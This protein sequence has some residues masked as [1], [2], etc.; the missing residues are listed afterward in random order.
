MNTLMQKNII[1][2]NACGS[3]FSY[4]L[5]DNNDFLITEYKV[6]QSRT[7]NGFVKC[8]KMMNNGQVELYYLTS[9]FRS[10]ADVKKNLTSEIFLTIVLNIFTSI[11]NAKN[12]GFL[13]CQNID[14]SF[15]K[16][17]IDANT[18]KVSLI[19]LPLSKNLFQDYSI[20]EN[21]LRTSLIKFISKSPKLI[22]PKVMQLFEELSNGQI[23]LTELCEHINGGVKMNKGDGDT[24]NFDKKVNSK[25]S[26][27][28]INTQYKFEIEISKDEFVIGKNQN[29]DGVITFNNAISR[30]H[31]KITKVKG[32]FYITD[33]R[34]VNG[35]YVNKIKLANNY[36][37]QLSNGDIIRLANSDF[38]V[39]IK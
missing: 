39:I 22:S 1:R 14:I 38:Q 11:I 6:L 37:K 20:F 24:N 12:N 35:T 29:V 27:V 3:N 8:M 19:Y 34:S 30:K 23:S 16:I 4:I 2:E 13:L 10:F 7:N 31:C 9:G 36:S 25:M 17:F 28:A 32:V 21:E 18:L 33:L 15:E 5:S 26:M